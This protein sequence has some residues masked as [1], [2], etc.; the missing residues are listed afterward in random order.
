MDDNQ[1]SDSPRHSLRSIALDSVPVDLREHLLTWA[2][3]NHI[4][5][6]SDPFW[7]IATALVQ[8]LAAAKNV[9][10][11]LQAFQAEMIRVPGLILNGTQM[12]TRDVGM[13]IE[14]KTTE[15]G[16]ALVE[17]IRLTIKSS[18]DAI[19]ESSAQ[20][21]KAIQSA[22]AALEDDL[23]RLSQTKGAEFIEKWKAALATSIATQ[24]KISIQKAFAIR[25]GAVATSLFVAIA[26]GT[27]L[28]AI[29]MKEITPTLSEVGARLV[30]NQ[31]IIEHPKNVVWCYNNTALCVQ[32]RFHI[33]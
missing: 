2:A 29:I 11:I 17:A 22:A 27:L 8:A 14:N 13:V 24:S 10:D 16:G 28:G 4:A 30:G 31:V 32:P 19:T 7:P 20:G 6:S 5:S 33:R 25:W 23:K 15:A 12:A 9:G 26:I 1:N 21:A 18:Q 3:E